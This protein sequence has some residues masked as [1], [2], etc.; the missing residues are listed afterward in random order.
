MCATIV[1]PSSGLWNKLVK[2]TLRLVLVFVIHLEIL[3]SHVL[4][5]RCPHFIHLLVF[6]LFNWSRTVLNLLHWLKWLYWSHLDWD[7]SHL[8][9]LLGDSKEHRLL[10]YIWLWA[11]K[12]LK[13][14]LRI[15]SH[16]FPNVFLLSFIVDYV[17]RLVRRNSRVHHWSLYHLLIVILGSYILLYYTSPFIMLSLE[18]SWIVLSH[19]ILRDKLNSS[20]WL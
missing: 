3:S 17:L 16:L 10:N 11:I 4:R 2:R 19:Y 15:Y 1:L 9:W 20:L 14:A 8:Y 12:R 13:T 6:I 5:F 7:W 18:I